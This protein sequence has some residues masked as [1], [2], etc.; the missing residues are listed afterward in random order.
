MAKAD[1]LDLYNAK[2]NFDLTAEPKGTQRA[3]GGN[4]FL[5]QKHDATRLHYDLRLEVDGVL[6][7]WAVTRG[8][9]IDP[10]DKR[11]AVRTEDHPL[12]YADFEGAIPAKEYGGGTVMLWDEGTWAPI[13][14]KSASDIDEGHLHFTVDGTRMNGEWILIRM[15]PRA[16]ETRENWLLRKVEDAY[17]GTGDGLVEQA[18]TSVRSGRTMREIADGVAAK[19]KP[20]PKAKPRPKS[21]ANTT[22]AHHL[23][24]FQPPQL[25]SLADQVP[26]GPGWMHEIKFDGYRCLIAA[27]RDRVVI[28]T[29]T[30]LDW[31]DRFRSIAE[32]IAELDLSGALIDGEIVAPGPDGNPSF[33]AL[34]QALK[35][36]REDFTLFA[37]DL[38]VLDG[39]DLTALSNIERKGRLTALLPDQGI[40]RVAAHV[41]GAGEKL[42][43]AM[44]DA[45]QEGIVSKKVDAPYAG[46][47]TRGWLKIKC[48]RREEFVIVGWMP[49]AARGR[50]FKSLLLAQHGPDGLVY[51]GKVGTGFDGALLDQL[52][53][54]M[55]PLARKTA[56]VAAPASEVRGAHWITEKLVAEIAFAECTADNVVRHA[57]FIGLRE[58]KPAADVVREALVAPP[59]ALPLVGISHPDR[60]IFPDDGITKGQLARYYQTIAPLMLPWASFRPISLV[61]CPQGRGKQCFFQK[62]DSG[63]FGDDVFAVDITDKTG[64]AEPYIYIKDT[65]GLIAC[66]QMGTIECHGWGARIDDVE[67][68]DRMVFDLDPDE[69]LGFDDV[70]RAAEDIRAQ[71]ADIRLVSFA[72]LSGGKGIHVVVPLTPDAEWPLVKDFASRFATALAQAEPSRFT[73]TMS[74]AKRKGRIFIDWLRNQ[75]GATAVIPYS[76]RARANAPLA[77]PAGWR[78]LSEIDT[79]SRYTVADVEALIARAADPSLVGWGKAAQ[80]L[81]DY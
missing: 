49:S 13:A 30:G 52:A 19:T 62:H 3:G 33:S 15:K 28:H 43:K 21:K 18:L 12:A 35:A 74:K 71:L 81:P 68:P 79:A 80:R 66:V 78:E 42:L 25:A 64:K 27:D 26:T 40:I 60:V 53:G 69:G 14:G 23:P 72:L 9:S 7:S 70:K 57:S 24:A 50:P 10:A 11:L 65:A 67:R 47:R 32:A 17:S 55:A 56:T 34:Q 38:L 2:R 76:V 63:S 41:I 29:R 8:P 5:V 48:T 73:A 39:Q 46:R 45:G 58:D 37:F 75:R 36:G 77:V 51:V 44:C 59:P 54:A 61:R 22:K 16:K 6:K 4:R 31:T 20:T 1:P